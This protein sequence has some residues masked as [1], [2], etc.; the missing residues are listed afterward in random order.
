MFL[1]DSGDEFVDLSLPYF[2]QRLITCPL[3]PFYLSSLCLL[4]VTME[5]SSLLLPSSLACSEH[6]APSAV[7]PFQFLVYYSVFFCGMGVSL[8]RGLC[9]FIP[10]VAVGIPPATYLLICWSPS[11]KQVWSQ[12][13][14]AKEP[15]CFFSIT[16]HGEALYG[17]RV[18]GVRVLILL[19]SF[20]SANCSS[21]ISAKFLTYGAHTVCFCPLVAILDPLPIF[22]LN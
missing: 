20:F 1:T 7:C 5:I 14:V 13:L 18:Q 2:R 8:S 21:S 19:G 12:Y 16:W 15:S 6:T 11:P 3:L 10:G 4:K 17:L 9:W 22:I